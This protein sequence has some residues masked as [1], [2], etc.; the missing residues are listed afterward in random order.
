MLGSKNRK[1]EIYKEILK[2]IKLRQIIALTGI[3]R[4]GKTTLLLKIINDL[5][6]DIKPER[7]MY[8][9]FDDFRDVEINDVIKMFPR[10]T[11]CDLR[12]G[13]YFF[14]FDEIQKVKG[15]EEKIKRIY[16]KEMGLNLLDI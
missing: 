1:R 7:I 9:S 5:L 3:R 15:W 8:F 13:K 6:K 4:V 2:Y 10:L 12:T 16:D 14:L 11:D